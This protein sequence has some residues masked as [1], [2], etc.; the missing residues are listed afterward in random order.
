MKR[1]HFSRRLRKAEGV[2]GSNP[3][4]SYPGPERRSGAGEGVKGVDK[5][6]FGP[7]RSEFEGGLEGGVEAI[8]PGIG[9][10]SVQFDLCETR[11]FRPF[12]DTAVIC[13]SPEPGGGLSP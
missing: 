12:A 13:V 4:G 6:S 9:G 3:V 1:F 5:F 7:I 10:Q 8:T 2:E 11:Q